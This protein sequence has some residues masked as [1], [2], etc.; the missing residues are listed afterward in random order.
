MKLDAIYET[1]GLGLEVII[2]ILGIAIACAIVYAYIRTIL[3]WYEVDE[4]GNYLH[5]THRNNKETTK[6]VENGTADN[7]QDD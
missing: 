3:W 4:D 2:V 7:R 6:T 1:M 5:G